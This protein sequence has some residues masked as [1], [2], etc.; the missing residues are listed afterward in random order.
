MN[1]AA[2]LPRVVVQSAGAEVPQR[3][4]ISKDSTS[5]LPKL[6]CVLRGKCPV[7]NS[8]EEQQ[9]RRHKAALIP[10]SHRAATAKRAA[11]TAAQGSA[12][13]ATRNR[14][15]REEP[16]AR[17]IKG[18]FLTRQGRGHF[19]KRFEVS[20]KKELTFAYTSP[21]MLSQSRSVR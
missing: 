4:A 16:N 3:A 15:K 17:E 10:L 1:F 11:Q 6:R 13:A 21:T 14:T 8:C 5:T 12:P 19:T 18:T 7:R 9:V 2:G 20:P